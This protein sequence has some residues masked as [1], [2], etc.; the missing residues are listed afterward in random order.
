MHTMFDILILIVMFG[1]LISLG[2]GLYFL[3]HDRGRTER[4]VISLSVR[5]GL[6]VLL[7]IL[8]AFAFMS[9]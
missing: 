3:V 6:S 2:V 7:L 4:T 9:R 1:I 5:V 8:L